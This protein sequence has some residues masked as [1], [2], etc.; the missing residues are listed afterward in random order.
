VKDNELTDVATVSAANN[1]KVG[2]MI[3]EAMS[4]VGRQ[5][6]MTIEEEKSAKINI[7]FVSTRDYEPNHKQAEDRKLRKLMKQKAKGATRELR[8]DNYFLAEAKA[9]DKA[10]M[11]AEKTKEHWR[12]RDFL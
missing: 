6:I 5:G 11:D 10:R 8:K 9:R 7:I 3:A 2:N 4:K 1:P 12:A